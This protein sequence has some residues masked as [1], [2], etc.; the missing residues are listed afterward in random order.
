MVCL[1]DFRIAR[2]YLAK[3]PNSEVEMLSISALRLM[4]NRT[5]C[6]NARML[7]EF[8]LASLLLLRAYT[9]SSFYSIHLAFG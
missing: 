7:R 4:R 2:K 9:A 6:F 5:P 8:I 3:A 1:G